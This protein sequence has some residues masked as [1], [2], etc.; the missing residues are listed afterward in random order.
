VDRL[1]L[2]ESLADVLSETVVRMR[3]VLTAKERL[4]FAG[5]GAEKGVHVMLP[6]GD[7]SE[8]VRH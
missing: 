6:G 5:T 7:L 3:N 4:T 2:F 1:Q 8:V